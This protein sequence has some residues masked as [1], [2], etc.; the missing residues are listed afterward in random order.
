MRGISPG[1]ICQ[2]DG[3]NLLAVRLELPHDARVRCRG[4][5]TAGYLLGKVRR[6]FLL[7]VNRMARDYGGE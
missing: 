2:S 3:A 1:I 4:G 7:R 6:R 5:G